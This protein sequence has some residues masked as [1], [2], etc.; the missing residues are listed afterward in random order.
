MH[1]PDTGGEMLWLAHNNINYTIA[2]KKAQN[3]C[4]STKILIWFLT[5]SYLH[6]K[7]NYKPQSCNSDD[8]MP[9]SHWMRSG[10]NHTDNLW[11]TKWYKFFTEHCDFPLTVI[12]QSVLFVRHTMGMNKELVQQHQLIF[13]Q[14]LF[15]I[16]YFPSLRPMPHTTNYSYQ[17]HYHT[18][19]KGHKSTY[20]YNSMRRNT[21]SYSNLYYYQKITSRKLLLMIIKSQQLTLDHSTS[22]VPVN[23][24][25]KKEHLWWQ[26]LI[27]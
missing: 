14:S 13:W 17:V 18:P 25:N 9:A 27:M 19:H 24:N 2:L 20:K 6:K 10:F 22:T 5:L 3:F 11:C 23:Q 21:E 4:N 1:A 26:S 16:L 15:L 8:W 12:I 7:K